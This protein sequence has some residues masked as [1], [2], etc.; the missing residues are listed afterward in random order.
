MLVYKSTAIFAYEGE[1]EGE[2]MIVTP[3][4]DVCLPGKCIIDVI[5]R[6]C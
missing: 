2:F 4:L 3:W 1:G 5:F 6:E